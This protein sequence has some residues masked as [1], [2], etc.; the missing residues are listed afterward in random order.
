MTS[1]ET[2]TKVFLKQLDQ[3]VNDLSV[4]SALAE[5]WRN[6]RSKQ[7]GG[8]RLTEEGYRMMT[9]DLDVSFYE[10]PY[11]PDMNFTTQIIIWLDNFIDCPYYLDKRSMFVSDDKKALELHMFSGDIKKYGISKALARQDAKND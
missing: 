10:V 9:E 8:M 1:K 2:Y 11:A 5:W 6:P 7:K 3:P 4:R